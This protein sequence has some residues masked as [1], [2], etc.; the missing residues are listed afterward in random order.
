MD[1]LTATALA[2]EARRQELRARVA[3]LQGNAETQASLA[4]L[5]SSTN[6]DTNR[7]LQTALV[8]LAALESGAGPGLSADFGAYSSIDQALRVERFAGKSA[9]VDYIKA[10]PACGEAEAVA[11]WGEAGM[12]AT[13][14][15]VLLQDPEALGQ[16]YRS[17]LASMGLTADTSWES[18]RAWIVATAKSVIMGA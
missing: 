16:V 18:Q 3:K 4:T 2:N 14:L 13:G 1:P 7:R 17:N 15:S 6:G 11:A 9:S 8:E 5:I 10:N 12:A